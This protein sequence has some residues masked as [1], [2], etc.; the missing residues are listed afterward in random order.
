MLKRLITAAVGVVG[1]VVIGLG[2]ASAT[3]WRADDVLVAD[4]VR[5]TRTPWSTDPGVLEL[6][7]DPVTV[8]VTRA[9]RRPRSSW[10]S[11]ATPTSPA[12]WAPTRTD[13]SPGCTSW[14]ELAVDDVEDTRPSPRRRPRTRRPP[15]P[16]RRRRD[17]R[18]DRAPRPTRRRPRPTRPGRTC[19]SPR[20]R[21]TGRPTLVWPQQ[22]GRWSLIAVSTG[23]SA[24]TLSM[25]WPRVVT[26]PWLWPCVVVGGLLLVLL[27]GAGSCCATSAAH[28]QGLDEPSGTP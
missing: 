4:D 16:P 9:G 6:G 22:E 20:R 17:P 15:P 21:A 18:A 27:V 7:G 5:R 13:R 12:G 23:E 19:G 2:V 8:T 25:A 1:L 28:A 11:V 14:H 26:T 10:R 24:P 3:V